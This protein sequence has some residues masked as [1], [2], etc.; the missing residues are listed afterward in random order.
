MRGEDWEWRRVG[1]EEIT[2]CLSSLQ[3]PLCPWM[4]FHYIKGPRPSE[5]LS[6]LSQERAAA[7]EASGQESRAQERGSAILGDHCQPQCLCTCQIWNVSVVEVLGAHS[8]L[9]LG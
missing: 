5:A 6:A 7:T 4:L 2:S 1:F 3:E 8:V 9:D